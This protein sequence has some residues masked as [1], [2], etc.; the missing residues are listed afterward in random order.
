MRFPRAA[1]RRLVWAAAFFCAVEGAVGA[2]DAGQ[3]AAAGRLDPWFTSGMV[4]QCGRPIPVSGR[5]TRAG[6]EVAVRF[7]DD[8]RRCVAGPDTRW[9]VE[10]PP[11]SAGGPFVLIV[12]FNDG[13]PPVVRDDLLLGDVW[14]CAGQS[15]MAW[16]LENSPYGAA[17]A[18]R[19]DD[20]S[21]RILSVPRG[22]A[23]SP[24]GAEAMAPRAWRRLTSESAA[25]FS[26]VAFHF[27]R[28]LR[29]RMPERPVGLVAAAWP[30]TFIESWIDGASLA[31][32]PDGEAILARWAWL[33]A[34]HETLKTRQD[35]RIAAWTGRHGARFRHWEAV[36]VT[37]P[38]RPARP[39]G[40]P[41]PGSHM[42]PS[43]LYNAMIHPLT[44]LPVRGVL[45]YQGESNSDRAFQY[46][47][48]LPLLFKSWRA[49]W[50]DADLPFVVV[51]L[52]D[53]DPALN[54][55]DRQDGGPWEVLRES[56]ATAVAADPRAALVVSLGFG[57]RTDVHPPNKHL[58][59]ERAAAV[60]LRLVHGHASDGDAPVFVRAIADGNALLLHFS[61]DDAALATLDGGPPTGFVLAGAD[62]V[63]HPADAEMVAPAIVRLTSARVPVPVAAR[64]AW[65]GAPVFNLVNAAGVP[66]STF[67]SDDWPLP[68]EEAVEPY[69]WL[70]LTPGARQTLP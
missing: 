67:R 46:R 39:F 20:K 63:F 17:A 64:H 26:A 8:S 22:T 35:E 53:A 49:T 32:S 4:L 45:W 58:L 48:L 30:G 68:T 62:R 55:Y 9:R 3:D 21:L 33:D 18:R 56:Q 69:A 28:A 27:G 31:A 11:R 36:R 14:L 15:N 66:L 25:G 44:A 13:T 50:G 6:A 59:G 23:A 43:A 41:K 38:F 51:Q 24:V 40:P 16:T 57:L 60:A 34:H 37:G 19:V 54:P 70:A 10:F 2:A 12:D 42:A 47:R 5:A 29:A 61:P 52:P 1:K 65:A 7:G